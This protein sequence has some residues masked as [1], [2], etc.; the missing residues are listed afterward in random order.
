MGETGVVLLL[1]EKQRTLF[2]IHE[3]QFSSYRAGISTLGRGDILWRGIRANW[4]STVKGSKE[5]RIA[6]IRNCLLRR[7][8]SAKL[9]CCLRRHAACQELRHG[10]ASRLPRLIW[11]WDSELCCSSMWALMIQPGEPLRIS[12]VSTCLWGQ[13]QKVWGSAG[14]CLILLISGKD[15]DWSP[16]ILLGSLCGWYCWKGFGLWGAG[17]AEEE[18]NSSDKVVWG[19][20]DNRLCNLV[21]RVLIICNLVRRV[22]IMLVWEGVSFFEKKAGEQWK[23]F[24]ITGNSSCRMEKDLFD[25][26][27]KK[28]NI[29]LSRFTSIPA[30]FCKCTHFYTFESQWTDKVLQFDVKKEVF[31]IAQ[32]LHNL[33]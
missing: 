16:Y 22:L 31:T 12:Q 10:I 20:L 1:T 19:C 24:F 27:I 29:S 26:N 11:C 8:L 7:N 30:Y 21:R 5:R 32:T 33:F 9:P 18:W 13:G 28:K 4:A 6:V 3:L 15:S 14:V 2:L 17:T 23:V 25:T